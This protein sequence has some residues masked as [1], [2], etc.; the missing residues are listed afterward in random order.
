MEYLALPRKTE[1]FQQPPSAELVEA[2]CR[3]MLGESP[4]SAREIGGGAF[5]NT[6][7]IAA[8]DGRK[9]AI[10]ITPP[11]DHPLLFA[12]ER[13]L[14]RR[15]YGLTPFLASAGPLLPRIT[16]TDFTC[17]LANRDAILSEFIEGE[18]WG[19]LWRDMPQAENDML[20]AQL[21]QLI[22]RVNTVRGERFGWAS[23]GESFARWSEFI[24][25]TSRG[26]LKDYARFGLDDTEPCEYIQTLEQGVTMLDE[27]TTPQLVHGD[28]WPNNV[29]IKRNGGCAKI[30]GLLDH[31]RGLWGDPMNEWVYYQIGYPP[32]YWRTWG[33]RP[34][35]RSAEFRAYAYQGLNTHQY[36]LEGHRY[37]FDAAPVRAK[38]KEITGK[39]RQLL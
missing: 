36:I 27:I 13:Y 19:A 11:H 26:L 18:N 23:P 16:C 17:Q 25:F 2:F 7:V 33:E 20:F 31:E 14:L 12:N 28:P 3:R 38:L 4:A 29:L 8:R 6:F 22:R 37:H 5:N 35:G 39:M 30:V 15:E 9:Y 32:A 1:E 34:S 10:R 24:L 21:G